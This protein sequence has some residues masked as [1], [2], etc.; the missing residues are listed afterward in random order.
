M[1]TAVMLSIKPRWIE[2]I[3]AFKKMLELRKSKPNLKTPFKCYIYCT[4]DRRGLEIEEDRDPTWLFGTDNDF[5]KVV[6]EFTCDYIERY[7]TMY[8]SNY[9]TFYMKE[10]DGEILSS[11]NFGETCLTEDDFF[12][13]GGGNDL[14]GWHISNLKIYSEPKLLADFG[15]TRA[16]QSWCYIRTA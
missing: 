14:F 2:L 12:A 9:A 15:L 3:A 16:P 13:Y 1:E 10:E 4:K 5:G 6:G 11:I 7:V 8:S